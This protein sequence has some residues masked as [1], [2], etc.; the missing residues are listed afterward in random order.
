MR[1]MK[2][3][4]FTSLLL[5]C[6]TACGSFG[7]VTG[8]G[9]GESS[10]RLVSWNVQTFFDAEADGSEYKD[11]VSDKRWGVAAYSER[12]RRLCDCLTVLDADVIVLVEVENEAVLRDI[13]NY[14]CSGWLPGKRYRHAVFSKEK[15]SSLGCAVL[16]RHPLE[17]L[18]CHGLDARATS[19]TAAFRKSPSLRP[20]MQVSV[21]KDG[22]RLT[23]LVNHWKSMSGGAGESEV[24]R[25]AQESMLAERMEEL[26]SI[27]AV[28]CGDF[29]RDVQD[30]A[31]GDDGLVV[32]RSGKKRIAVRSPWIP[33]DGEPVGPGSYYYK[34]EWSRI[35]G[36]LCA[37]RAELEDFRP[38]TGGPWCQEETKIPRKYK[39][40]NGQGYSD[41]LPISCTV[42]F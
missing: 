28:A 29:N 3:I 38:E 25:A 27:P 15:G 41:H 20:L 19:G 30:F 23:L 12:L 10:I 5:A 36:F 2:N 1:V 16:S 37:G 9:N 22:K 31:G 6:L 32:L 8:S 39:V 26:G 11:F 18:S 35:D 42:L 33:A 24:W 13:S 21:V 40:W 7:A 34:E 14:L 4:V 17:D